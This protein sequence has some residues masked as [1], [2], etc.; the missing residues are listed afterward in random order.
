[1]KYKLVL[2]AFISFIL[3]SF[4]TD[5]NVKIKIKDG[6]ASVD[7]KP[8]LKVKKCNQL[9]KECSVRNLKDE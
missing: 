7:G 4:S 9:H 5:I 6:I 1:M 2:I 8:Y 3:I